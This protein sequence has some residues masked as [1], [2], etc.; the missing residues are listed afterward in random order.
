MI[1]FQSYAVV[2]FGALMII[3]AAGWRV[4]GGLLRPV[5]LLRDTARRITETDLSERIAVTGR[6]DLS[7]LARTVNAML[8]RL[9]LAFGSQRRL[10]DDLGHELRT[11]LTIVRGH[12]EPAGSSSGSNGAPAHGP[13]GG[14]TVR[15]WACRSSPRSPPRTAER[16]VWNRPLGPHPR[17][18]PT[19]RTR[20]RCS[21]GPGS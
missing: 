2:A 6:D 3:A 1:S 9:Q 12:L 17:S 18:P 7:D 5:R 14:P 4:V 16:S 20:G 8:D 13:C 11:P 19:G 15:V 21:A 10:L